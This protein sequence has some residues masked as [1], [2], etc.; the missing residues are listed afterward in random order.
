MSL[1]IHDD[2]ILYNIIYK[3]IAYNVPYHV[4]I[5]TRSLLIINGYNVCYI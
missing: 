5:H 1:F 4:I 3:Q 2:K